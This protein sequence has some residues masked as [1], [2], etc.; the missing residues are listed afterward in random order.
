M[1]KPVDEAVA[2]T[3]ILI[4]DIVRGEYEIDFPCLGLGQ[5]A[6][7][8]FCHGH[9]PGIFRCISLSLVIEVVFVV[10]LR[11]KSPYTSWSSQRWSLTCLIVFDGM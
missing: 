2:V 9:A 5:V 3:L 6:L 4:H 11:R 8:Q 10:F 1:W 7:F